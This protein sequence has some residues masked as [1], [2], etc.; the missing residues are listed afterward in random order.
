MRENVT[1]GGRL[2]GGNE[3]VLVIAEI[4]S[5]HD[6]NRD[7]AKR[8]IDAAADAGADAVKFQLFSADVLYP[9]G[10]DLYQI[11]KNLELPREWVPELAAHAAARGVVFLASP[12][13]IGAID[14]LAASNAPAYKIASSETT[15]LPLV[16]HAAAQ[17]QPVLI[18]T[19]MCDL[20]DIHEAIE[21][22]KGAGN[23]QVAL[24]QCSALYPS[25][26][27][28][29]NLRVMDTLRHAFHVPVGF[30]DHSLGLTVPIVAA[31][32]GACMIE[33]H[34][35]LDREGSGPDHFYALEPADFAAMV[36]GIR[37]ARA[38]LGSWQKQMLVEESREARRESLRAARDLAAGTTLTAD[39]LTAAR[40]ANGIRPRLIGGLV[41]RRLTTDV[42]KGEIVTWEALTR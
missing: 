29:A 27:D 5:N 12:F 25:T 39:D 20:A 33:K 3:P 17:G 31:A 32:L 19:G 15:N 30:S 13:D 9:Q 2:V 4:G 26:P 38:S 10:G 28:Q 24:F 40:P 16:A 21:V 42:A 41:G 34:F 7:Q 6:K 11:I 14:V 1:I 23:D 37:E 18:S 36:T 22:V 8:L 35:T